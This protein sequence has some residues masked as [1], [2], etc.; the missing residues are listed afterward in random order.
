M[1]VTLD[2]EPE[3]C[4]QSAAAWREFQNLL[5]LRQTGSKRKQKR[6]KRENIEE[7]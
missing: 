4:R 7:K 6:E 2:Y 1:F 5:G 3:I